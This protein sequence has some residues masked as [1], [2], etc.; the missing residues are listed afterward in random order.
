MDPAKF[1]L[2]SAGSSSIMAFQRA[3][4]RRPPDTM[5]LVAFLFA[6]KQIKPPKAA[7][8][9]AARAVLRAYDMITVSTP[10]RL[11]QLLHACQ[12]S[13][14]DGPLCYGHGSRS[15][16]V[17]DYLLELKATTVPTEKTNT[18]LLAFPYHH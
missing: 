15:R 14:Q 16:I 4:G 17:Q 11:H 13:D 2:S 10:C 9:I 1:E 6:P 12:C 18:K 8:S 7:D 5:S 3:A